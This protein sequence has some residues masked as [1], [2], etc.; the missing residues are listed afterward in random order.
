MESYLEFCADVYYLK[1]TFSPQLSSS[2]YKK[3][4]GSGKI[5]EVDERK[6]II[7]KCPPDAQQFDAAFRAVIQSPS[8]KKLWESFEPKLP[9]RGRDINV[10][11]A[12]KLYINVLGA[13]GLQRN[14]KKRSSGTRKKCNAKVKV[15]VGEQMMSTQIIEDTND[16]EWREYMCFGV[17]HVNEGSIF[18][19]IVD[20]KGLKE[21]VL[22]YIKIRIMH[23]KGRKRASKDISLRKGALSLEFEL[24][25]FVPFYYRNL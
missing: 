12:G 16:P 21:E 20:C 19:Q 11:N 18:I 4:V 6:E 2:I 1:R 24:K 10:N 3:F 23:L 15:R 5:A 13:H 9:K 17:N 25:T 7:D 8:M 22:D 14:Q